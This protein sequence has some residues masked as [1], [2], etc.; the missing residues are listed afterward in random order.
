MCL[1]IFE[2]GGKITW[3]W[4]EVTTWTH[5]IKLPWEKQSSPISIPVIFRVCHWDLLMVI[6]DQPFR[7][8]WSF[9]DSKIYRWLSKEYVVQ[10]SFLIE[11]NLWFQQ[12]FLSKTKIYS[13]LLIQTTSNSKSPI[14]KTK[15]KYITEK[16]RTKRILN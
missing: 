16:L 14:T 10:S 5:H 13:Q 4:G 8:N 11:K 12:I 9:L 6:V 1:A 15:I 2:D 3:F 7:V